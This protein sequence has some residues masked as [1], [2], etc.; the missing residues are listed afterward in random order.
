MGKVEWQYLLFYFLVYQLSPGP[1]VSILFHQGPSFP[2]SKSKGQ[3]PYTGTGVERRVG[4]G[5]WPLGASVDVGIRLKWN[6][7]GRRN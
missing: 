6:V 1:G 4:G 3:L 2:I 5:R 7:L